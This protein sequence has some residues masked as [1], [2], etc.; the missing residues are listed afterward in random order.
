MIYAKPHPKVVAVL[1]EN[2]NALE[3]YKHHL[4]DSLS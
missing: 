4:P 1:K 2:S 3:M